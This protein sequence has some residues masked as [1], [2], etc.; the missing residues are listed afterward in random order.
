[1]G[2]NSRTYGSRYVLK[3]ELLL[4]VCKATDLQIDLK[5]VVRVFEAVFYFRLDE[6]EKVIILKIRRRRKGYV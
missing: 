6:L 1:M 2:L 3:Q 4:L 5:E